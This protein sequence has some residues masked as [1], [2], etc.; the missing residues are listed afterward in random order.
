M[1]I[2]RTSPLTGRELT[3][4]LPITPAEIRAYEQGAL[5]QDAFPNLSP[6]QREFYKT[7]YTAD[8]WKAIFPPEEEE[9]DDE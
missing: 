3:L 7:G 4:D 1:K 5:L 8:D 9:E 2:T 6:G